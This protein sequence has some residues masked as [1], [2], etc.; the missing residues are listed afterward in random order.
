M[1][2]GQNDVFHRGHRVAGAVCNVVADFDR[3]IQSFR[4]LSQDEADAIRPN[5]VDLYT[6]RAGDTW[7]SIAQRAGDR[8]RD[9]PNAGDHERSCRRRSAEARTTDQDRR[10]RVLMFRNYPSWESSRCQSCSSSVTSLASSQ[11]IAPCQA[12]NAS[13]LLRYTLAEP[14]RLGFRSLR[15]DDGERTPAVCRVVDAPHDCGF[16]VR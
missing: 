1:W 13:G 2:L 8:S 14:P 12:T 3:T 6:A 16:R 4:Q 7:Q 10:R 9:C 5:L 11:H 15:D